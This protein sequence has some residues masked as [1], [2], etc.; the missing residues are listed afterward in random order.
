MILIVLA[1]GPLIPKAC[2]FTAGGT[3]HKHPPQIVQHLTTNNLPVSHRESVKINK[4]RKY[5]AVE[6]SYE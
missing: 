5:R 3:P 4:L 6:L 2:I 1:D